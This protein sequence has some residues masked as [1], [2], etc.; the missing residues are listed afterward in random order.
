MKKQTGVG[1]PAPNFTA[2]STEGK[3]NFPKDYQGLW[4][5]LF[6]YI[7]D[8]SPSAA[9]D[10]LM[11][12][13]A[14][15]KFAAYNAKIAAI[16]PDSLQT[17]IAWVLALRNLKTDGKAI[18]F[19]LIADRNGQ[20]SDLYNI[21][22]TDDFMQNNEK[23]IMIID[24]DG[25]IRSV[26]RLSEG[27]GINVTETERELLSLQTARYQNALTPAG[28]TPGDDIISYPPTTSKDAASAVAQNE[29]QGMYCLDWY[30]CFK[31]DSGKRNEN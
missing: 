26:H 9:S 10:I 17:H 16:S 18:S 1:S 29:A 6:W 12:E 21:T 22:N 30:L 14:A 23:A 3:V 20:I 13:G 2:K 15:A 27:S 4:T 28:W 5:V 31:Q 24:P 11:L 7:D 25:I 19:P 8:F